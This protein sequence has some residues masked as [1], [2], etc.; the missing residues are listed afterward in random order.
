MRGYVGADAD[1]GG[2]VLGCSPLLQC[3]GGG[4]SAGDTKGEN[5]RCGEE[6]IHGVPPWRIEQTPSPHARRMFK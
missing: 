1:F 4:Q 3:L 5:E 2:I 6:V